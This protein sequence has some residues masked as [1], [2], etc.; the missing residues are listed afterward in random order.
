MSRNNLICRVRTADVIK[1]TATFL[2][3][4][5]QMHIFRKPFY[6]IRSPTY[7]IVVGGRLELEP[8]F[9]SLSRPIRV[10]DEFDE[11]ISPGGQHFQ[12]GALV[13]QD[14]YCWIR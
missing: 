4:L 14:S 10:G 9:E 2:T 3:V 7:R 11:E 12:L 1:S 6:Q 8:R 5:A 13:A